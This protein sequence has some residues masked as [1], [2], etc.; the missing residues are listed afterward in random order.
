MYLIQ[1]RRTHPTQ[2]TIPLGG[3]PPKRNARLAG[4]PSRQATSVCLGK[5]RAAGVRQGRAVGQEKTT[6]S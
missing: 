3:L 2:K 1:L 6:G 4:V 5:D